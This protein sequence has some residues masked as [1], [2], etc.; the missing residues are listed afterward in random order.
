[1]TN[2]PAENQDSKR[3]L[4]RAEREEAQLLEKLDNI[5]SLRGDL[6]L[7][8]VGHVYRKNA[9]GKMTACPKIYQVVEDD[10][11]G[12]MYGPG[13]YQVSYLATDSSGKIIRKTVCY[14]CGVEY[15]RLHREY[16]LEN[17]IEPAQEPRSGG[18]G[19]DFAGILQ[20]EK[21]EGLAAVV[22]LI[23]SLF[24]RDD[25]SN[26]QMME[27]I[28]VMAAGSGRSVL[29]ENLMSVL[30]T[31]AIDGPKQQNPLHQVREQISFLHELKDLTSGGN[32]SSQASNDNDEKEEG[33]PMDLILKSIM[34]MLPGILANFNN[35][36][37][38]AAASFK[39]NP[40]VS[41][42][43][44]N[45][46]KQKEFYAAVMAKHGK[47]VADDMARG[48]GF[49]P[50]QFQVEKKEIPNAGYRVL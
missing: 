7:E 28:K 31:K 30:L 33:G 36:A 2:E 35:N 26:R 15:R 18:L 23:T 11:L 29:P 22:A 47:Q 37:A 40:M 25:S 21:I 14:S 24:K 39:N 16:C 44:S 20:K 45:P 43:V 10:D 50:R 42:Y 1:M 49:D 9:Y 6:I 8:V 48:F 38:A 19:F 41:P 17:G 5:A 27:L 32:S 46:V 12:R 3:P 4:T 34:P 13:D